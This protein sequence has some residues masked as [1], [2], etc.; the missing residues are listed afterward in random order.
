MVFEGEKTEKAIFDS[1]KKYFLKNRTNRIVYGF[2]CGEIYSLYN[3]LQKSDEQTLFFIL[4]ESLKSKNPE[5]ENIVQEYVE[6][7]YLFFDYDSHTPSADDK[8]LKN[9]L[10]FFD[11]E[12]ENG[13]LYISY[14]MAES[15]KHL[16]S[17]VHFENI[18]AN[19]NREYKDIVSKNGDTKF[20]D[21]N[22]LSKR[23]WNI[24]IN[25]HC[26]KANF[27]VNNIFELPTKII[28]QNIIFQNQQSKYINYD[29]KVAVLSAFP[30]FLADYYGYTKIKK[31]IGDNI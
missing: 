10:D 15:I 29:N 21:L 18:I 7:I 22:S 1:L 5:L 27:I 2:H 20:K 8:I 14:P 3:K 19:S 25:E 13:K 28:E 11:D 12:F 6:S 24:I 16:Q 26:K 23:S 30:L 31:M 9:M 17:K 4:K